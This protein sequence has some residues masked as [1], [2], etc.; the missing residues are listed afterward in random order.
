MN[1]F[2]IVEE[3]IEKNQ[4]DVVMTPPITEIDIG[5]YYAPYAPREFHEVT[6]VVVLKSEY[7]KG[8][9]S[10][11]EYYGQFVNMP[12][13]DAVVAKIGKEAILKST[14]AYFSDIPQSIWDNLDGTIHTLINKEQIKAAGET[15]ATMCFDV[16]VAKIAA[17]I[18]KESN[19]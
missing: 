6:E 17:L 11:R 16:K 14:N 10:P 7:K 3:I 18:F 15:I 13:L 4:A 9:H 5:K 12:I 19:G 1:L 8:N 2:D